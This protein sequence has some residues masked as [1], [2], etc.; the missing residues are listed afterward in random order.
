MIFD[1][2]SNNNINLVCIFTTNNPWLF[3]AY[4]NTLLNGASIFS[5]KYPKNEIK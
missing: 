2:K 1:Y 4:I 3:N 5:K